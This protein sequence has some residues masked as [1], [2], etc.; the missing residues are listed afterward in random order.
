MAD[1]H[2]YIR[3]N[4]KET[5]CYGVIEENSNF[6]VVCDDENQ[7]GVWCGDLEFTPKNWDQVCKY[8]EENYDP[9]IEQIEVV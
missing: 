7:D 8:L 3:K 2:V 6:A 5:W 4:G 9:N 1:K